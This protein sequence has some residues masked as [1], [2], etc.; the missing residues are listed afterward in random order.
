MD[1]DYRAMLWAVL[2]RTTQL[3]VEVESIMRDSTNSDTV[4]GAILQ[5]AELRRLMADVESK[6]N[7]PDEN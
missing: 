2:A 7:R 5:L 4:D 3:I 1:P 6:L